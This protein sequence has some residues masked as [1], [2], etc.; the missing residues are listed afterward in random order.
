MRGADGGTGNA[1]VELYD[2]DGPG[3]QSQ[4]VALSVRSVVG[5]GD[6]VQIGGFVIGGATARTV[7]IRS[8]G[9]SLGALF[10]VSGVLPDPE[11]ELHDQSDARVIGTAEGWD[12]LLASH[13]YA[14]GA[15]PWPDGSSDSALVRT[16]DPGVYTVI[17]R[18]AAGDTGVA[19]I[20]IYA[21]K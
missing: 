21:E 7:V 6:A 14:V 15:F 10:G 1:L 20:E 16:L 12:D 13:F 4:L 2:A 5:T 17:V 8:S 18:G 3:A 19:L 11:L 9:P